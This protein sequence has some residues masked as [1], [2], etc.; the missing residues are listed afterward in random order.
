MLHAITN[1]EMN[2]GRRRRGDTDIRS[3]PEGSYRGLPVYPKSGCRKCTCGRTISANKSN[4]F[5]CA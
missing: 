5:S 4:C 1:R 3:K 2:N